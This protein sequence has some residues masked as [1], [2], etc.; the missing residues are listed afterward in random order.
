M[1]KICQDISFA[2]DD[3]YK[4]SID[5]VTRIELQG[6]YAQ[7][8][9]PLF[10]VSRPQ[11]EVRPDALSSAR[12]LQLHFVLNKWNTYFPNNLVW[13]QIYRDLY[14]FSQRTATEH[15]QMN[16]RI[17][18]PSL[19]A[20]IRP[21]IYRLL[22]LEP[23]KDGVV[24]DNIIEE[25]CRLGSLIYLAPVW[26]KLGV[27]PVR[28]EVLIRKLKASLLPQM[29]WMELWPLRLWCLYMGALEAKRIEDVNWFV[30]QI[31]SDAGEYGLRGCKSIRKCV[32][33]VLW[34]DSI[35]DGL[36]THL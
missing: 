6:A 7:D 21:T 13:L 22:T 26:R 1:Y 5:C 27:F 18:S 29:Y 8:S 20:W 9:K 25:A 30:S 32:K 35:F 4:F 19:G 33:E 31:A 24:N 36:D 17:L 10:C 12:L 14:I 23:L 2:L 16:L 34:I 28:T 11:L 3:L 15:A